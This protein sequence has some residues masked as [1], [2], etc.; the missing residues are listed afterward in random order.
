ME[1]RTM[2]VKIKR[3]DFCEILRQTGVA[4]KPDNQFRDAWLD[5]KVNVLFTDQGAGVMTPDRIKKITDPRLKKVLGQIEDANEEEEEIVLIKDKDE[6]EDDEAEGLEEVDE[7][8]VVEVEDEADPEDDEEGE[9]EDEGDESDEEE[10]EEEEVVTAAAEAPA[11]RASKGGGKGKPSG[12]KA[13]KPSKPGGKGKPKPVG[14]P[15]KAKK[16]KA[17]SNGDRGARGG[18]SVVGYAEELLR[19]ASKRDPLTRDEIFEA[20]KRKFQGRDETK[21]KKAS[22]DVL[23]W[24]LPRKAS[25]GDKL[26][27]D[28]KEPARLRSYWIEK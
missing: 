13:P 22:S 2:A 14:V 28:G 26:K 15:T 18:D 1:K 8:E 24:F 10:D 12:P 27:N 7:E 23:T 25:V 9:E 20:F 3:A 5:E 19:K 17:S 11:K 21:L 4:K 16:V 6:E